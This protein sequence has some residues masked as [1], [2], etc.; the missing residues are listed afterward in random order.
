MQ[1]NLLLSLSLFCAGSV[2]MQ[3]L[4][5]WA[6]SSDAGAM[7]GI[8]YDANGAV[9]P[10]ASLTATNADTGLTFTVKTNDRG[11][12]RFSQLPPA[13]YTLV[14]DQPGFKQ[15]KGTKITVEVGVIANVSPKLEIG[16]NTETVEVSN[17]SPLMHTESAEISSVI[18]QNEIDNLPINGRRAS[19]FALLTPGVVSNGDG[20][21]LLSFRGISFLL[22]NSQIDGLDDNQAYFSEQRGRTRAAYNISQTAVQE[23]Q[24]NTSNF[25][26]EYGRSAGGVINTVTKSG[27]NQFH[28][29]LF[30]YDRDNEFGASN[31]Y[32]V[33]TSLNPTLGNYITQN[34]K[35]RDWRKQWGFGVGGPI[36]RDRL[37]FFYSYDQSRRNFPGTATAST[38]T[39]GTFAPANMTLP[40][41]NTCNN[42]GVY[43]PQ[44][45]Q[46][47]VTGAYTAS[48]L[49]GNLGACSLAY[50][51]G[52]NSAGSAA[53]YEAGAALYQQG[54]GVLASFLGP[55]PR[56]S[57]QV[58]NLPKLDYQINQRNHL[59][60]EANRL[61]ANS[62]NG[63]QTQQSNTYG[64]GSFGNDFVKQDYEI[65]RLATTL[66]ST[67]VNE[68]R[69]QYGRDFEYE[70]SSTPTGNELPLTANQ[71][72]FPPDVNIGYDYDANG[73]D[74]GTNP[75]LQRRALPDERRL[76]GSDV[77]TWSHGKNVTK[78]G[79]DINRVKD[80]IDN[81]Y[82]ENGSYSTD[83]APQ[84]IA[85]YLHYTTGLGGTGYT[86]QYYDFSQGFGRRSAE[87]STTDYAGF[88][89]NDVRLTPRLTLTAGLRYEYQYIPQNPYPN[90]T[91]ITGPYKGQTFTLTSPV[92]Q[93]LDKPDDR[94]NIQPRVGFA[95][96]VYG[97]GKT[98][99]RGG[100][101]YYFGRIPNANILQVYL[102][103]GG[104]NSQLRVSSPGATTCQPQLVFP[105]IFPSGLAG[106]LQFA[107]QC[108]ATTSKTGAY[109]AGAQ[110]S[111]AYLDPH[112]QNPQVQE[113]DMAIEQNL[114]NQTVISVSYLGSLARELASAVDR[115]L[116]LSGTSNVTYTAVNTQ[117]PPAQ[118]YQPPLPRGGVKFPP[119]PVG[120]Q[121]TLKTYTGGSN[122]RTQGGLF[123]V[124]QLL[125]FK[126]DVNASYNA[127]SVQISRRFS[128]N[129]GFLAHY[130]WAH[131][132]D[133]NPYLSTGDGTN[134]QLD[135]NNL[136]QEYGNSALNVRNRFVVAGYYRT[137]F[138]SGNRLERTLQNGWE[139]AVI[140]QTQTGLPF[141]AGTAKT[142]PNATYSGIIGAGGINRL[143]K[144]DA[145]G[146][147]LAARNE[148][149]QPD[150]AVV[151]LRLSRSFYMDESFGHFRLE[152]LGEAF[153]LLNHQNITAVNTNAYTV[154]SAATSTPAFVDPRLV[155]GSSNCPNSGNVLLYNPYFGT[156]KN[157]NSNTT[158]T[159][160]QLE[161]SIRLHF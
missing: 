40:A 64:R 77:Y 109:V 91:G 117:F 99:L 115:N 16:G 120:Q 123:G 61:R 23:F 6:Q 97:N 103:S 30:F 130:T 113:I 18:D 25:S 3:P 131:A 74:I 133:Y 85:D 20:F 51:L 78:A 105:N 12:Y 132:L 136:S 56:N 32:T 106:A 156:N 60:L 41:G 93:T 152:L 58:I 151:D 141:S 159:P 144:F 33:L 66:N 7:A 45:V 83:T 104:P 9:V 98:F 129:F 28:G 94:N 59:I 54:L 116:A 67:M 1:R 52:L 55:V 17:E 13:V 21:G 14:V 149:T 15:F 140:A 47:Q 102:A 68:V 44:P 26:A 37:F 2:A 75:I 5:A 19:T 39:A 71:F 146:G 62:P 119:I 27:G 142:A 10:G 100:Y 107:E 80:Y 126:S 8:V 82:D 22:N 161:G 46:N 90:T 112:L 160:R 128:Q 124:Y 34:Y 95:L 11:E 70:S 145:F 87:I 121:V 69:F 79:V 155:V 50:V 57:D 72:G 38:A 125:D 86:E 42:V 48:Y 147:L 143:P 31:P 29:E 53:G 92:P 35:P 154:C 137:N 153:N 111:V 135:P 4:T 96:D 81:L 84:F 49:T 73:F 148:Y 89:S 65:A 157:S 63:V 43:A 139:T 158:Y 76:Q 118:G 138:S 36:I 127:L 101:G 134:Q 24:V 110:T 114:G 88:L 108:G 150:I 122:D